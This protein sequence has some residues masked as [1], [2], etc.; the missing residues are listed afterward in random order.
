MLGIALTRKIWHLYVTWAVL[1]SS[2]LPISLHANALFSVPFNGRLPPLYELPLPKSIPQGI[3]NIN[4]NGAENE[5]D[6]RFF[7]GGSVSGGLAAVGRL[8][9]ARGANLTDSASGKLAEESNAN[10]AR[11]LSGRLAAMR[12]RLQGSQN[13]KL[14]ENFIIQSVVQN[15]LVQALEEHRKRHNTLKEMVMRGNYNFNIHKNWFVF[16]DQENTRFILNSLGSDSNNADSVPPY[17]FGDSEINGEQHNMTR[18]LMKDDVGPQKKI[19]KTFNT[20]DGD[21]ALPEKSPEAMNTNKKWL[22]TA[23]FKLPSVQQD[24]IEKKNHLRKD[25]RPLVRKR[26]D[27]KAIMYLP[28]GST[29]PGPGNCPD[30]VDAAAVSISQLVF[31]SLCLGVF[32]A[33]ANVAN[34]INNNNNNNNNNNDN[35]INSNNLNFAANANAGNQITVQIPPG[36]RRKR[37]LILSTVRDRIRRRVQLAVGEIVMTRT[38]PQNNPVFFYLLQKNPVFFDL[39]SAKYKGYANLSIHKTV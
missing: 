30:S 28:V 38:Q 2:V 19:N 8:A 32:T 26:R 31:L 1:P 39:L 11:I 23:D 17:A 33:V 9:G 36:R 6:E 10:F 25:F 24:K 27:N 15:V 4:H 22:K 14:S 12:G 21:S 7:N 13:D 16:S 29:G 35:N 3:M 34:N 18:I 5:R 20:E 37:D